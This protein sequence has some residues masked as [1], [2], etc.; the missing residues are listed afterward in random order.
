MSHSVNST[1]AAH[2]SP[3]VH[4]VPLVAKVFP[5][6]PIVLVTHPYGSVFVAGKPEQ[7]A[8]AKFSQ[9]NLLHSSNVLIVVLPTLRTGSSGL[10]I[11]LLGNYRTA[12]QRKITSVALEGFPSAEWRATMLSGTNDPSESQAARTTRRTCRRHRTARTQR[13]Q[14][15]EG[16]MEDTTPWQQPQLTAI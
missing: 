3:V 13:S 11:V 4:V 1:H 6:A 16:S 8:T 9:L 14:I 10:I 7:A 12:S 5:F 2:I 15:T